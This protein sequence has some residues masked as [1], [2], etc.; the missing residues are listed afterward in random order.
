MDLVIGPD[1]QYTTIPCDSVQQIFLNH[2]DEKDKDM[3]LLL[4]II[5]KNG[6]EINLLSTQFT[7]KIEQDTIAPNIF[8]S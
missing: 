4:K 6:G 7:L 3:K 5:L 1:F 2:Y 8:I